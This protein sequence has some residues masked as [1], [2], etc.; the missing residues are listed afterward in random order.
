MRAAA[1][2]EY[3]KSRPPQG[4]LDLGKIISKTRCAKVFKTIFNGIEVAIKV[5]RKPSAKLSA[6]TWRNK[7]DILRKLVYIGT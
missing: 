1:R 6:I 2:Q 5:C 7:V 4:D 3:L